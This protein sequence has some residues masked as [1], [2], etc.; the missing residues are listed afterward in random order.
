MDE[1]LL[2]MQFIILSGQIRFIGIVSGAKSN[3]DRIKISGLEAWRV[4]VLKLS[5]SGKIT[6]LCRL[7][8]CDSFYHR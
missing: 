5:L 1:P 4:G 8:L 6:Y 7:Q 3:K 2:A